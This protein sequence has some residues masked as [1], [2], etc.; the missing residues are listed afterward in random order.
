MFSQTAVREVVPVIVTTINCGRCH[1]QSLISVR[2]ELNHDCQHGSFPGDAVFFVF[3]GRPV[4]AGWPKILVL[5]PES[6]TEIDWKVK[7]EFQW[8][9]A[10]VLNKCRYFNIVT[11]KEYDN[12]LK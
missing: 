4:Q 10:D 1:D 5:P 6:E 9:L 8:D 3:L 12:Y 2:M 7:Q 11:Q